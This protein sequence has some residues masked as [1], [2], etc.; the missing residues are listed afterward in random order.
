MAEFPYVGVTG[1]LKTCF[2][3]IQRVGVPSAADKKWLASIGFSASNDARILLVLK[4]IGFV[5]PSG[6]PT[7]RW[8]GYRDKRLS[9]KV[10]AEG[11]IAGYSE[12]FGTYP[13]ANQKNEEDLRA[14]FSTR[15][16]AG[17]QVI[18]RT[19]GTFKALCELADFSAS[20]AEVAVS[21]VPAPVQQEET[22]LSLVTPTVNSTQH[23]VTIN[24]NVQL[25]LPETTD[26]AVYDKLFAA[27]KKHL[28]S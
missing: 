27:M 12:L 6:S 26:E 24:I 16:S 18:N 28:L 5:D 2:D 10:L 23:G 4:F 25:T 9:G 17:T 8:R 20:P 13:Q 19:V 1:R 14:F 11:I 7:D 3:K 15:T 22:G 21:E